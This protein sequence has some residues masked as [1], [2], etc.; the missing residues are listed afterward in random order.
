MKKFIFLMLLALF[1]LLV[2][3]GNL[4][5]DNFSNFYIGTEISANKI[6][7]E[8][9]GRNTAGNF[10]QSDYDNKD[11]ELKGAFGIN[12]GVNLSKFRFDASW[13]NYPTVNFVTQSCQSVAPCNGSGNWNYFTKVK[14][15]KNFMLNG[16]Y[17]FYSLDKLKFFAGA[18]LGVA[19]VK[20]SVYDSHSDGT[21]QVV[22]SNENEKTNFIWQLNA[23]VTYEINKYL[24][25]DGK[26]QYKNLGDVSG[27]LLQT[28]GDAGNYSV[29]LES[30]N[31]LAGLRYNFR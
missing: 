23:G 3:A 18:G 14:I 7:M 28:S 27:N 6:D 21:G 19:D 17:N 16:S 31:L 5:S 8:S 10:N 13:I 4:I 24:D 15:T 20:F 30:W 1:P 25:L 12:A 22:H 29:D 9:G 2:K 26:I 11:N